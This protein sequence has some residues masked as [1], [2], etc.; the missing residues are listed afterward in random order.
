[1]GPRVPGPGEPPPAAVSLGDSFSS[2]EAGRWLGNATNPAGA[3]SG[4]DRA[5][6]AGGY[7]P[8]LV[9]LPPS[10]ANGCHRSDVAPIRSAGLAGLAGLEVVNLACSGA[11]TG[12]VRAA[13]SGGAVHNGEAP[14]ADQL[15]ELAATRAVALVTVQVG[16]NDLGYADI[17]AQCAVA[18]VIGAGPCNG[19]RASLV[20]RQLPAVRAR[21]A[22]ALASVRAA[23]PEARLVLETYASPV[24]RAADARYPES[25]FRRLLEGGCPFYDADL[26]W[27]RDSLTPLLADA[28]AEVAAAQSVELLDLRH[29]LDGREVCARSSA[30]VGQQG[31]DPS[32]SE[33]A[34]FVT[35]GLGQGDRV[36]S[37]H[38]N[39]F[40]QAAIGRCLALLWERRPGRAWTCRPAPGRGPE[41]MVLTPADSGP[42]AIPRI[43]S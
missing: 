37:L 39:A 38:P 30:L 18:Y 34:R 40:G 24:P 9:Y 14:Q 27:A 11:L 29:A 31:P 12:H 13:A 20:R 2:G 32:R 19:V 35:T 41:A 16:G 15:A 36:E 26:T 8:S 7:D 17:I 25:G 22:E 5:Y 1:V 23:A 4:T 10:D 21:V 3:R 6:A 33:W 43:A 42:T 28:L